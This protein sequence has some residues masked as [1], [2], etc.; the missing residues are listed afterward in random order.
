MATLKTMY[1]YCVDTTIQELLMSF[2]RLSEEQ[3]E[4]ALAAANGV[5][6]DANRVVSVVFTDQKSANDFMNALQAEQTLLKIPVR[7]FTK[8]GT[9]Y[10]VT[11]DKNSYRVVRCSCPDYVNRSET[12]PNHVCKH[13]QKVKDNL[14]SYL[15]ANHLRRV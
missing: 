3:R 8:Y 4:A 5:L 1:T 15:I 10:I 6:F 11:V 7:S 13:M 9:N 12:N 2:S 14:T